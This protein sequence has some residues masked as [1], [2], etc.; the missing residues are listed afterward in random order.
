MKVLI[1]VSGNSGGISPFVKEQV[2]SLIELGISFDYFFI[3]GKGTIGYLKNFSYLNYTINNINYDLVHAHYGLSGLLATIQVRV[4]VLITFH[5]SDI[6]LRKNYIFSRLAANL[7]TNNIFVHPNL[8]KKLKLF[9]KNLNIIPCGVDTKTF[10]P[11]PMKTARKLLGFDTN[12]RYIL[13][14]SAFDNPIKNA[15]LAIKAAK[16]L[17]N[18]QLIELKDYTKNEVNLLMNASDLL[19]ITSFS[20]TGPIVA[21]E[22]IA[23]NCPIVSTDVGDVKILINNIRNCF[24]T[25]FDHNEIKEKINFIFDSKKRSNGSETMKNFSLEIIAKKILKIYRTFEKNIN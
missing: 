4:P 21:K 14:S 2:D 10:K 16:R 19:L 1:V 9:S 13:F 20:E 12:S 24:I 5:G 15:P 11:M 7:S 22:A 8:P 18:V 3:K 25:N 23:C 6:N 17:K